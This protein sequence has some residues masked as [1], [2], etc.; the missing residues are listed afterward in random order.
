M[1]VIEVT[2]GPHRSLRFEINEH[3]TLLAGRSTSA[4]LCLK[5]DPYFSRFHFRL[6][7]NPPNCYF[8]DL[9]SKNGTEINGQRATERF[10]IDGDIISGGRTKLRLS[11]FPDENKQPSLKTTVRQPALA[12]LPE[13]YIVKSREADEDTPASIPWRIPG[14]DILE[15]I[16]RGGMGVVYRGI[17][18]ATSQEV[19]LKVILPHQD[20]S[21]RALQLFLREVNNLCQLNHRRI[22]AFKEFGIF[23][24]QL[25]LAMEYVKTIELRSVLDE[26]SERATIRIPCAIACQVLE[27]LEYAHARSLVHR[28]IK[29]TNILLSKPSKK[30]RVKLADFGL[31]KNYLNAGFSGMT[32]EGESRGTLAFMPP[33]QVIDSRYAKPSAD[34]YAVGATL[35]SLLCNQPHI[36]FRPGQS[37]FAAVLEVDPVPL[38]D[39]RSDIPGELAAIVHRALQKEPEQRYQSAEEMRQALEPFAKRR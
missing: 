2:E 30:L 16:G 15:E 1:V 22:V 24:G 37:A 23:G 33:E 3:T 20:A 14:Y 25:F 35:Y 19:A 21:D 4:Q 5:D 17:Q 18:K 13:Q 32:S 11:V 31:S 28:D 8:V 10:L 36:D 29:P 6:E 12:R 9:G 38:R 26:L 39:R 27:A 34:V 7:L